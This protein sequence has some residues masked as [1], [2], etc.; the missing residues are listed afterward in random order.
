M[1]DLVYH[2]D[3]DL[4]YKTYMEVLLRQGAQIGMGSN[5]Q[6]VCLLEMLQWKMVWK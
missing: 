5:Y 3:S 6:L 4:A 1:L 2:T